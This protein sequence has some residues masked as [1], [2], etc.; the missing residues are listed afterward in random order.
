MYN[1]KIAIVTGAYEGIGKEVANE[2]QLN[3]CH[4]VKLDLQYDNYNQDIE[5]NS[6]TYKIDVTKEKQ[7]KKVFEEIFRKFGRI[8][9]LVNAVGGTLHSKKIE[10]IDENDWDC[11]FDLNL[12]SAFFCTKY[13]TNYMKKY[14]WG[15]VVNVSAVAGRTST[16]F[17][18][19]DFASAKA[20]LIGFTRQCGFE[21]APYGITVNAIAPGLTLTDRVEKM[22]NDYSKDDKEHIMNRVPIGRPSTVSEQSKTISFLCSDDASYICGAVLDTN[23]AM[24]IG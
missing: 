19:V 9:I 13:A 24:F 1:K 23:G 22:W 21:L 2:L 10:E 6:T 18:G 15:R 17:G 12:K 5:S 11:S 14:E 3:D 8:D 4:V 16:F 7:V 20:A